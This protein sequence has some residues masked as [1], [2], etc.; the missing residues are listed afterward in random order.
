MG[1][2]L[3]V[4]MF[5]KAVIAGSLMGIGLLHVVPM[6]Q[7]KI[8]FLDIGQ[9]DSILL[10]QQTTQVLVDGG[11]GT[12]VLERLGEEL[13]WFDRTIEVVVATHPDKDHLEGLLHVLE[14]YDVKLVL[15]PQIAHTS[16][17]QNEWLAM[18]QTALEKKEIEYRFAWAGEVLSVG[19]LKVQV[20]GPRADTIR[21]AATGKTNNAG[22][23]TR[24]DM[25]E[26]SVLL[27]ADNEQRVEDALVRGVS[28]ALLDVDVLKAGHHG[29]KTSTSQALLDAASPSL[30]AISVGAKN[31][32]GHPHPTVLARLKDIRTLRT[33]QSGSI[34]LTRMGN[35]WFLTCGATKK[36]YN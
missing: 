34:R 29:S 33:D 36:C 25:G 18:L 23:V 19:D 4:M 31:R 1:V 11:P 5:Y 27:T 15:L 2:H 21:L 30:V 9:G 16:Q 7:D 13:P 32:Y 14:R 22:V 12:A 8:V 3:Y 10:Q 20:L 28:S 24:V 6:P 17:L 26:L 35:Q